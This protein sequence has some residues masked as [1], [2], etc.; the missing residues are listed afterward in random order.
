MKRATNEEPLP[1]L[2][3]PWEPR[4]GVSDASA[5]R[6]IVAESNRPENRSW[7]RARPVVGPSVLPALDGFG[8]LTVW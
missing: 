3:P 2:V 6:Q 7:E 5:R 8:S 1:R 4:L